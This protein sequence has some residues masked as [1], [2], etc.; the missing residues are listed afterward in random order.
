LT[1]SNTEL[2]ITT[3]LFYFF[4]HDPVIIGYPFAVEDVT[5]LGMGIIYENSCS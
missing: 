2:E 5:I 4:Q 1:A 3:T